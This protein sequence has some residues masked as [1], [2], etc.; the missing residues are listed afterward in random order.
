MTRWK[1][2]LKKDSYSELEPVAQYLE[3]VAAYLLVNVEL[4]E[5]LRRIEQVGVVN[6]PR[7]RSVSCCQIGN[8][9]IVLLD[10]PGKERQVED[11]RHPVAVDE[12]EEG[13]ETVHRGL[14]DNVGVE[15]VAEVNGVDVVTVVVCD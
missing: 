12:E 2:S 15:S 14:G 7:V 9:V 1:P 11:E 4:A 8:S 6:N 3:S 10:I 13:Q 5:N